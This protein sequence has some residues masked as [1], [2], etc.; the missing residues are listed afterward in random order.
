[1]LTNLTCKCYKKCLE[2]QA[3][4]P[5][6]HIQTQTHTRVCV[7]EYIECFE[8]GMTNNIATWRP[9]SLSVRTFH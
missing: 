5:S 7:C 9:S 8:V 4:G 3:N 6:V 2:N 1:M